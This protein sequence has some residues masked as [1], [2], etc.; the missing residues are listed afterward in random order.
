MD[1]VTQTKY[2]KNPTYTGN[3][4][5]YIPSSKAGNSKL[6]CAEVCVQVG[7]QESQGKLGKGVPNGC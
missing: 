1:V 3:T 4:I 5:P 2:D 7:K 6:R